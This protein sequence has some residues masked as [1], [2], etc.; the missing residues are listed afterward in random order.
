MNGHLSKCRLWSSS[1]NPLW[2]YVDQDLGGWITTLF[3]AWEAIVLCIS[4][5]NFIVFFIELSLA[6]CN[7][8]SYLCKKTQAGIF[9][10]LTQTANTK[11]WNASWVQRNIQSY[12]FST[13]GL[14]HIKQKCHKTAVSIVVYG[15]GQL[16]TSGCWRCSCCCKSEFQARTGSVCQPQII[17]F[18]IQKD[19]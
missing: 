12:V 18:Q 2:I 17:L 19:I 14:K 1:G 16:S 6:A 7:H 10:F 9:S 8:G 15:P 11:W 4:Y 5:F 3:S 13:L